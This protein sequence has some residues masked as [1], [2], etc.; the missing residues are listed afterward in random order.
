MNTSAELLASAR[1]HNNFQ[2]LDVTAVVI[3]FNPSPGELT[4]LLASLLPQV[5]EAL[6]I[7]N[8]SHID[9]DAIC[10]VLVCRNF[11][12]H[13]LDKNVGIAAAQNVG[14]GR[15]ISAG[16]AYVLL[17]D[18]DS[19]PAPDMVFAL[20]C[21]AESRQMNDGRLAAVGPCFMDTRQANPP[22]FILI[23]NFRMER[24]F[25]NGSRTPV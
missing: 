25:D 7:D 9:V 12:V 22:P 13:R 1:A 23:K 8:H 10:E 19:E 3:T 6:V 24:Q 16:A 11:S 5:R 20:R 2:C 18:Q 17:S 15:A 21:E 14:I 4:A